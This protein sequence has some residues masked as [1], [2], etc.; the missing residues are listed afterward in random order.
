MKDVKRLFLLDYLKLLTLASIAVLHTNEFIFYEDISPVGKAAPIWYT[1]C[2]GGRF[3]AL[4]GQILVATV[5]FL[6]GLTQKKRLNFFLIFLFCL[7]G[8]IVLT[9]IFE[10]PEWDIYSYLAST[11]LL[12][13]LVPFFYKLTLPTMIFSFL[14]LWIPTSLLKSLGTGFFWAILTGKTEAGL[15][16]S[17]PLLPWFFLALL[18]Y[19]LGMFA[20]KN[21]EWTKNITKY[22]ILVWVL[23]M[24]LSTPWLGAYYWSPL[25][26]TFYIFN[27]NKAPWIF[28]ANFLPFVLIMRLSLLEKLNAALGRSR[29]TDFVSKLYWV[30]HLGLTYLVSICYLG[31]GLAAEETFRN[32]PLI[33][34]LYFVGLMP[35]SELV[36]RLLVALK[37]KAHRSGKKHERIPLNH[38]PEKQPDIKGQ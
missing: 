1:L 37:K 10:I 18:F 33:F 32:S 15:T 13:A 36:S 22:E 7:V 3:F 12:I 4:G 9:L 31:I 27:F 16:G 24:L 5:F 34:D 2:L 8:Q 25:G 11:S 29:V 23:F 38:G 30:R 14:I 20:I 6:F 21:R 17:W 28:W 26:P 19:Q 35:V